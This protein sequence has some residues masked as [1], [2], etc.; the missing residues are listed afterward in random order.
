MYDEWRKVLAFKADTSLV[1]SGSGFFRLRLSDQWSAIWRLDEMGGVCREWGVYCG[2]GERK[3]G[4]DV[5]SGLNRQRRFV[6]VL[7]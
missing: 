4:R 5:A 6:D 7:R 1:G 3:G 2:G